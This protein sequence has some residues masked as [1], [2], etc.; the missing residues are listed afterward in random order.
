MYPL[1]LSSEI[2]IK[3]SVTKPTELAA[4]NE[5]GKTDVWNSK[6]TQITR[7]HSI[8]NM[9]AAQIIAQIIDG[10]QLTSVLR[11]RAINSL[12]IIRHQKLVSFAI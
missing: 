2:L 10:K 9:P 12:D 4:H 1:G 6:E 8:S 3:S 11:S 5:C 7:K